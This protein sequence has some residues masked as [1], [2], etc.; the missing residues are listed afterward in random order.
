[1][2]KTAIVLSAVT[3]GMSGF[4][5]VYAWALGVGEAGMGEANLVSQEVEQENLSVTR[6]K[7]VDNASV[8]AQ[9]ADNSDIIY[10]GTNISNRYVK[11]DALR[12]NTEKADIYLS[13]PKSGMAA[14]RIRLV[15]RD[16]EKGI[17][18]VEADAKLETLEDEATDWAVD[19]INYQTPRYG[20]N[21]FLVTKKGELMK[22]RTGQLYYA[23]KFTEMDTTSSTKWG[24]ESIW[25][26]GKLDYRDCAASSMYDQKTMYCAMQEVAGTDRFQYVMKDAVT[27]KVV[28]SPENETTMTWDEEW[29][30]QQTEKYEQVYQAVRDLAGVLA[31]AE[32]ILD[33]NEEILTEVKLAVNSLGDEAAKQGLL[34]QIKGV[35]EMIANI[36]GEY[37]VKVD[38]GELEERIRILETEKAGL[39]IEKEQV[40]A[41]KQELEREKIRLEQEKSKLEQEKGELEQGKTE[42]EQEKERLEQEKGRLEQEQ[43]VLQARVQE[44]IKNEQ[45]L[46]GRIQ[47]LEN[48]KRQLESG[49]GAIGVDKK[50]L[51]Q[52]NSD[53]KAEIAKL[54]AEKG[55][56]AQKLQGALKERDQA[57]EEKITLEVEKKTLAEAKEAVSRE[58]ELAKTENGE[59][60]KAQVEFDEQKRKMEAE[61]EELARQNEELKAQNIKL[62]AGLGVTEAK[63]DD[64]KNTEGENKIN[65][66]QEETKK[67]HE[68]VSLMK[69]NQWL[70]AENERIQGEYDELVAKQEGS[71]QAVELEVKQAQFEGGQ[72][73]EQAVQGVEV[74]TLGEVTEKRSFWWLLIP[75]VVILGMMVYGFR[76][77]GQKKALKARK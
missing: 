34:E 17:S 20:T 55:E 36:R 9:S 75:G 40:V 33:A 56:L 61:K 2:K 64:V 59:L 18:E 60:R 13:E 7:S 22:N 76:S 52:E 47:T 37:L 48:E 21:W 54:T 69:T 11:F 58:F 31:G 77:L 65:G 45:E 62:Q 23:V 67:G 72:S 29:L 49:L 27:N 50:D 30:K 42:V 63:S 66:G 32:G 38:T 41:E 8:L 10:H 71:V 15:Y 51:M 6:I 73:L 70:A 74:P 57:R 24:E 68:E 1:M 19:V 12:T 28:N 53:L 14:E 43:A 35:E 3:L 39:L 4:G 25:V 26:R 16:Y 46:L 5:G 44:L